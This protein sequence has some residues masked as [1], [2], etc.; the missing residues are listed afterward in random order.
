MTAD[1]LGL[2]DADWTARLSA[3]AGAAVLSLLIS[4]ASDQI[5]NPGPSLTTETTEP[6][7][8]PEEPSTEEWLDGP[9]VA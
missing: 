5:G 2:L 9:P 1:G 6:V 4:V 3:A 7:D 8:A